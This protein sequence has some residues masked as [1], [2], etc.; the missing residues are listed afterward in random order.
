[1][2]IKIKLEE[3]HCSSVAA[4]IYIHNDV[5]VHKVARQDFL[6]RYRL[7]PH[8]QAMLGELALVFWV[9]CL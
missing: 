9:L 4:P 5:I 7:Q 2:R 1:M 3:S 8:L 6:H